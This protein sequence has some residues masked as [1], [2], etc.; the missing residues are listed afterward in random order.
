MS[1]FQYREIDLGPLAGDFYVVST[2]LSD[3]EEIAINGVFKIDAA[4]QLAGKPSMMNPGGGKTSTGHDHGN[5]DRGDDENS[6]TAMKMDKVDKNNIPDKFKVQLNDAVNEYLKVK[7]AFFASDAKEVDKF[8]KS[9]KLSL[10]KVD[11]KLLEGDEYMAWMDLLKMINFTLDKV[12]K[13]KNIDQKRVGFR[14]LSNNITT[15]IEKFGIKSDKTLYLEYCP[16]VDDNKGAYWISDNKE[17]QNPYFGQQMP[18]CGEVKKT[19]K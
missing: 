1:I 12:L 13:G 16:M 9:M 19:Y 6:E 17:I 14:S 7:D 10:K 15:S 11:M 4:A 18:K 2:G 8:A 5:M 3:G